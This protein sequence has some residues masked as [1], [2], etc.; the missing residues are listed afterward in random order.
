MKL[1]F[2]QV[3]SHSY[4]MR[5]IKLAVQFFTQVSTTMSAGIVQEQELLKYIP[6]TYHLTD[7]NK[8]PYIKYVGGRAG[9]FLW[10]SLNIFGIY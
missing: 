5:I 1:L 9:G 4:A 6:Y 10:G 8:G 2:R 7:A 3:T